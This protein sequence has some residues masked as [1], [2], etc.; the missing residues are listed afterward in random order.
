MSVTEYAACGSASHPECIADTS[1]FQRERLR[2][3]VI[4]NATSAAGTMK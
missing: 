4:T 3:T 2:S 1:G